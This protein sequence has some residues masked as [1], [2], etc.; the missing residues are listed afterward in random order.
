MNPKRTPPLIVA[1]LAI[2]L[3]GGLIFLVMKF[4]ISAKATEKKLE[5]KP[6][7]TGTE[8]SG[9]PTVD[10][11]ASEPISVPPDPEIPLPAI[12]TGETPLKIDAAQFP[13][14]LKRKRINREN[15]T[16]IFKH[17]SRKLNLT[18]AVTELKGLGFGKSAA[19][20]AFS[21]H[22]QFSAWLHFAPDGIITW[23]D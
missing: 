22:G 11:V 12:L 20:E 3:I 14:R 17:G 15:M 19:Y 16:T 4:L 2:L 23:T 6:V 21:A 1:I 13:P 7:N 9:K 5:I 8:N 10:P 18:T